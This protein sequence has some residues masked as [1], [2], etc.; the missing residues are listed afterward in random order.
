MR[1]LDKPQDDAEVVFLTCIGNMREG[2]LKTNLNSISCIVRDNA[3]EY[4]RKAGDSK[5]YKMSRNHVLPVS[6]GQL[7][8]VYENKLA[9]KGQPGRK[10]YDKLM[11][12][13]AQGICPL[14]GQR[15][16]STLDHYLP[17]AHFPILSVVPINLIAS[18]SECNKS[19]TDR[20]PQSAEEQT[21]HPY[22]DRVDETQWLYSDVITGN[23][24]SLRFYVAPPQGWSDVIKS[25]ISKHFESLKLGALYAAHSGSEI[26]VQKIM[27][28]KIFERAGK[29]GVFQHLQDSYESYAA[30]HIDSWQ[31]AMY[32]SLANNEWYCD[33]GFKNV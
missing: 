32:Q 20:V 27:L 7:Q 11:S 15:V 19:K 26:A 6:A 21:L 17:K 8:K 31:T 23:P 14:C 1:K 18:C 9:K 5:L 22:Y 16:V 33:G 10:V 24:V 2:P 13:P 29:D 3:E 28:S 12:I 30:I 25:R 4:E